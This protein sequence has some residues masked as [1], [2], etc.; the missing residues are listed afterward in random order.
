MDRKQQ[1]KKLT[2][3]MNR[4]GVK[5]TK[6]FILGIWVHIE[7]PNEQEAKKAAELFPGGDY[8]VKTGYSQVSNTW[9]CTAKVKR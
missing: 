5:V 9:K 4:A 2:Q 6:I 8:E 1:A 3:M 7:T